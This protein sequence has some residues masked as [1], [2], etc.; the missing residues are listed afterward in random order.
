MLNPDTP[1]HTLYL[2]YSVIRLDIL[3]FNTSN[4]A[5]TPLYPLLPHKRGD[6]SSLLN[7][8]T[9]TPILV[10]PFPLFFMQH[11][12]DNFKTPRGQS[13]YSHFS[14]RL[15]I[16]SFQ[17]PLVQF[18]IPFNPSSLTLHSFKSF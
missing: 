18:K 16:Q 1:R 13:T 5:P 15:S 17:I 8:S 12:Q 11:S 10:I 4:Q 14:F 3:L 2:Q 7:H 9:T 6:P